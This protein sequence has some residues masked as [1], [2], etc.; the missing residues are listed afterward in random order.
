MI[1]YIRDLTKYYIKI[2]SYD[3]YNKLGRWCHKQMPNCDDKVIERKIHFALLDNNFCIQN[4]EITQN[5][6]QTSK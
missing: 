3:N 1:Q 6:S 2:L 5:K 4:K